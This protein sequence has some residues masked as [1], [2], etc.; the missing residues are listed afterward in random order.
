MSKREAGGPTSVG[1]S[2]NSGT[3]V[4]HQ[5]QAETGRG[6]GPL[7]PTSLPRHEEKMVKTTELRSKNALDF[8][9]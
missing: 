5:W 6:L 4:T 8:I 1:R 2:V 7:T 9:S 3:S